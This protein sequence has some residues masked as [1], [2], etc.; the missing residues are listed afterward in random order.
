MSALKL[1]PKVNL[2]DP[3]YHD[4]DAARAHLETV[5]WP[6]GPVCPRCGVMGYRITKLQGKSTRPGVY[7]CKDCRK[8]FSVTVG[9][10]MERSHIP[11]STWVWSA[12]IM[13]SSKKGFSALELQRMIGTNYETAWFLFHRL[14]EAADALR[15]DS[16]MGG[17]GGII[18]ADE[19]YIGGKETNKHRNERSGK[20]GAVGKAPV[21]VLVERRGKSRAFHM[22]NVTAAKLQEALKK[23]VDAASVLMTDESNAYTTAG[24]RFTAHKKVDHSREEYAYRERKTGLLVTTNAAESYIALFKRGIYGT[25]HNISEAHL[26]RYLAE[27]DFRAN[28]RELSDRERCAAPLAATKGRRLVYENP[29]ETAHA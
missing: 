25:F 14:R 16:P 21:V 11:L 27:F 15:G 4:D 1:T 24:T 8:P 23:H 5:L 17:E 18:E 22:A 2:R 19:A 7:K 10:V 26:D 13:S 9:T 20:R 6:Q 28:T 3:I 29:H 12:Q